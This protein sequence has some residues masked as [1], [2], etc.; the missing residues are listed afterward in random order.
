MNS[1]TPSPWYAIHTKPRQEERAAENLG[2]WGVEICFPRTM[3]NKRDRVLKP[4][5]PR[6]LFARFDADTMLRKIKLTRGVS[7]VVGFGGA[8]TEV[9][10][11][12]I[13]LIRDRADGDL[14]IHRRHDF[15]PGDAVRILRGPFE[16]FVGVLEHEVR[17]AE[18]VRILLVSVGYTA[19]TEV[20]VTD[21]AKIALGAA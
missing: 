13:R 8:P 20:C 12:I 5:F 10:D 17:N 3:E 14:V 11:E 21:L 7:Y 19:R 15:A 6:Y 9:D 4:F 1:V 18:R 2:A 16:Q